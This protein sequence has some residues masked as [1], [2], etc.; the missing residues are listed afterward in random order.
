M[1]ELTKVRGT[2]VF[3]QED[4]A[5]SDPPEHIFPKWLRNFRPKGMTLVHEPGVEVRGRCIKRIG[6]HTFRSKGPEATT[7]KVCKECNQEWMSDLENQASQLLTPLIEG[8][9]VQLTLNDQIFISEWITKT[10]LMC[11]FLNPNDKVIPNSDYQDLYDDRSASK[12]CE[13]FLASYKGSRFGFIRPVQDHLIK[14]DTPPVPTVLE[15]PDGYRFILII[16]CLVFEVVGSC[17]E[18]LLGPKFPQMIPDALMQIW[19]STA[20][21]GWPL[22]VVL[23]DEGM[24]RFLDPPPGTGL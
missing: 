24:L 13:I 19:P 18:E 22:P 6:E 23:D 9:K 4:I 2:C 20:D 16:G 10:L 7:D 14:P 15:M 11:Q 3:C 12:F 17:N 8:E 5:A 1:S 21:K